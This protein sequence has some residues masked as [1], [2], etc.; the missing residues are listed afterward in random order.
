LEIAA[1]RSSQTDC[2][3]TGINGNITSKIKQGK[4]MALRQG[5]RQQME[6]LPPSIEQYVAADAPVRVYDIFVDS[7]NLQELV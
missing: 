6:Y 3:V 4:Y 7:L 5:N 2:V 1:L